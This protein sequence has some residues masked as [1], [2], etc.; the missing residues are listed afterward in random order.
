MNKRRY[1][2]KWILPKNNK[3][4]NRHRLYVGFVVQWK[5][6]NGRFPTRREYLDNIVGFLNTNK[7]NKAGKKT[8]ENHQ[9]FQ[10]IFF[11]MLIEEDGYIK[12]TDLGL[13]FMHDTYGKYNSSLILALLYNSTF[14]T[15]ATGSKPKYDNI[16]PIREMLNN[17]I[18][19]KYITFDDLNNKFYSDSPGIDIKTTKKIIG[20]PPIWS[21]V[22]SMLQ[23]AS[24]IT[25]NGNIMNLSVKDK[26]YDPTK[27]IF[28]TTILDLSLR[29]IK[30]LKTLQEWDDFISFDDITATLHSIKN[31][32]KV[33]IKEQQRDAV[34]QGLYRTSL[35][36]KYESCQMCG[37]KTNSLLVASH[38]KP[39]AKSE[40]IE[41]FDGDNG[42]LLCS[43]HDTLF[44]KGLL[45]I[46]NSK[47]VLSSRIEKSDLHAINKSISKKVKITKNMKKYLVFHNEH[48]FKK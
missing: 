40:D 38:I 33:S 13:Y 9:L 35:L 47:I 27:K 1:F 37:L 25:S 17:L 5:I 41:K 24:L 7:A 23:E 34:K 21:Y 45:T 44:D 6:D 42:L 4:L 3:G 29:K 10:P 28:P 46:I 19:Y 22:L 16:Y 31:S 14:A 39:Y 32:Y 8:A 30:D 48:V 26:N 11:N 20:K 36:F 15:G 2:D 43:L 12:P 18:K